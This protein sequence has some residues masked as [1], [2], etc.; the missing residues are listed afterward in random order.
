MIILTIGTLLTVQK[1]ARKIPKIFTII[2]IFLINDFNTEKF[3]LVLIIL[4]NQ[5]TFFTTLKIV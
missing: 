5:H 2:R 1:A 3:D 4:L